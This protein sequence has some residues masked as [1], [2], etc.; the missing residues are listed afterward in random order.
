MRSERG[1]SPDFIEDVGTETMSASVAEEESALLGAV[2]DE[3]SAIAR[4]LRE[5]YDLTEFLCT[6]ARLRLR[7]RAEGARRLRVYVRKN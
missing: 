4:P 1:A 7:L 3:E 5:T 2:A 6:S